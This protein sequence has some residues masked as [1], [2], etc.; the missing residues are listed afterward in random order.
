MCVAICSLL[1]EF[2]GTD[3][4]CDVLQSYMLMSGLK[5][6][7]GYS[8]RLSWDRLWLRGQLSNWFLCSEIVQNSNVSAREII[9]RVEY[10]CLVK[11]LFSILPIHRSLI[12]IRLLPCV[13]KVPLKVA[14]SLLLF[15]GTSEVRHIGISP[16]PWCWSA[17]GWNFQYMFNDLPGILCNCMSDFSQLC[18]QCMSMLVSWMC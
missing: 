4:L 14:L 18:L 2:P 10:R 9:H 11:F 3:I 13:I 17:L 1:L 7:Y 12:C 15:W 16:S 8:L 5:E 6:A